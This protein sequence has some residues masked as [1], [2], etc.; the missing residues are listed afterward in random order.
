MSS[1]G[2]L[3]LIEAVL[4]AGSWVR[5]DSPLAPEEGID[6]AYAGQLAAARATTGLDE[7]VVTG[8]GRIRGR[9]VALA[10]CEFGF[11]AG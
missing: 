10:A 6:P 7:A 4:D 8:E 9:R 1:P 11:L 2:A 3:E 5:W